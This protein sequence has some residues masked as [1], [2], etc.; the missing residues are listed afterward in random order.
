[1]VGVIISELPEGDYFQEGNCKREVSGYA[2]TELCWRYTRSIWK[3]GRFFSGGKF[4]DR[5]PCI[6]QRVI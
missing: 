1:M 3:Y 2:I 4:S 6:E 5:V